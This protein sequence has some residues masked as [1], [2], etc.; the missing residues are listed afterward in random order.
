MRLSHVDPFA[1]GF[2]RL[3]HGFDYAHYGDGLVVLRLDL[4]GAEEIAHFDYEVGEIIRHLRDGVV[5][6]V[7]VAEDEVEVG[8]WVR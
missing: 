2:D 8:L 4:A 3:V 1:G 5:C 6:A 7:L